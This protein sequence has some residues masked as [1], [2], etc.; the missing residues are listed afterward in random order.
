MEGFDFSNA[1]VQSDLPAA[2]FM[3]M[4]PGYEE[5]GT[6][7]KLNKSLYGLKQSG[8]LWSEKLAGHLS[9]LGFERLGADFSVFWRK[10]DDC[11][12]AIYTDDVVATGPDD[13]AV[14]RV[15]D[16]IRGEGFEVAR[17]C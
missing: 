16:E 1:Y 9:K 3:R 8:R 5:D 4:P 11:M 2:L 13:A 10:S 17:S 6:I 15:M 14:D 7:L 12:L